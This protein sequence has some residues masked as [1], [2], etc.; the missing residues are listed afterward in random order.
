M[1]ERWAAQGTSYA[2]CLQQSFNC[3]MFKFVPAVCG[4]WAD[5]RKVSYLCLPEGTAFKCE[6]I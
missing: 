4:E 2:K 1:M 6:E 5:I 3:G